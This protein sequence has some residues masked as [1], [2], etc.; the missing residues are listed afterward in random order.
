MS[1]APKCTHIV[2]LC[3]NDPHSV[4]MCV[5]VCSVPLDYNSQSLCIY[6]LGQLLISDMCKDLQENKGLL[7]VTEM[8]NVSLM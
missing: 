7:G 6:L 5:A 8:E 3:L 1:Q 2:T 4:F